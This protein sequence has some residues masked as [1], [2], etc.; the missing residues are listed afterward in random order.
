MLP[1]RFRSACL[2]RFLACAEFATKMSTVCNKAD[3]YLWNYLQSQWL[4]ENELNV[5]ARFASAVR[6]RQ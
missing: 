3:K 4:M 2:A 5:A 6:M 1:C